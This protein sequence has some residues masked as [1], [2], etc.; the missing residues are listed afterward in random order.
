MIVDQVDFSGQKI[1]VT[2]ASGFI[3]SH[4]C[5]HLTQ[6]GGEVHAVSR[7][8]RGDEN[9]LRWLQG[10]FSEITTVH[11]LMTA[12]RPDLIFHLAS[13]VVGT[14][15]LE[16]VLPTFQSNLVSTVNLLTVAS[17]IGCR[18]IVLIGS[19]EEPEVTDQQAVPSSPYAA[20]KWAG[21]AYGRM[22]H[23]L[24]QLPVVMLRVFMVYGPLQRDLSK[25]IPYVT[26]SLLRG[27]APK[28][29]SGLRP[30]DW[31]Y[32]EDVVQGLLAAALARDIEGRTI[33]IGSGHLVPIRTVVE[34]LV[35]LIDPQVKP[36]F[37]ALPDRSRE[38]VRVADT[39]SS[40]AM[41][42]WKPMT[43]V[44]EGLRRTVAWYKERLRE[45][46]L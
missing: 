21:S 10:D 32:V 6:C 29:S 24:Y 16:V 1:L 42:G 37:G 36:L 3:G 18:R 31:I 15:D 22:F 19:L 5:D 46:A 11:E 34:Q 33:D 12:V 7:M 14:R 41:I 28:L 39:G 26:L 4:L 20:A 44:E 40:Y 9:G 43:T 17:E 45:N 25:L 13:H 35:Q 8:K 30:V 2:G 27:D 38:Q 23:S